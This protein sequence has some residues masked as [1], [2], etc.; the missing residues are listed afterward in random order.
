MS[1]RSST[2]T[3]SPP[4]R[5]T[6]PEPYYGPIDVPLSPEPFYGPIDAPT[7]VQHSMAPLLQQFPPPVPTLPE[8]IFP[9]GVF[10]VDLPVRT[11]P[12]AQC[13]SS[14]MADR[15]I[16]HGLAA[17]P[18]RQ[19]QLRRAAQ[20]SLMAFMTPDP[21]SGERLRSEM[22]GSLMPLPGISAP[23][24]TE[25]WPRNYLLSVSDVNIF[26]QGDVDSIVQKLHL[27][28]KISGLEVLE[29]KEKMQNLRMSQ[30]TFLCNDL[31]AKKV[32]EFQFDIIVVNTDTELQRLNGRQEAFRKVLRNQ[33]DQMHASYGDG[34]ILAFDA[35]MYLLKAFAAT[36]PEGAMSSFQAMCLGLFVVKLGLYTQ[37]ISLGL[38]TATEPTGLMLFE[39]FLRWCGVYF[40]SQWRPDQKLKNYRFSALDLSTGRL[41]LRTRSRTKCEAYFAADEVHGLHT[42][43]A[44]RLNI[45]GSIS[46]E[47]VHDAARLA[48]VS[49]LSI[50][51]GE[52]VYR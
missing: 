39:C 42:H 24:H 1:S 2:G 23:D 26:V 7:L 12:C 46:P 40:G 33:R 19:K 43:S 38:S 47:L 5:A 18:E 35:Y 31:D 13:S 22:S 50:A 8:G 6:S 36:M 44:D 20:L 32:P 28:G 4:S 52:L 10:P 34:G 51:N 11:I 21:W 49:N 45:A 16:V 30:L 17:T 15:D 41:A 3:P 25:D 27:N 37:V 14:D 29:R 9:E 48:M